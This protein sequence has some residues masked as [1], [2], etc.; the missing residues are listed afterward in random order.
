MTLAEVGW[1]PRLTNGLC[2]TGGVIR[3]WAVVLA[4][5]VLMASCGS[6]VNQV[7][8][9]TAPEG[10][11]TQLWASG[12][13]RPT[14]MVFTPGGDLVIAELNGGENA[15][16]GRILLVASDDANDRVVLQ[17][18]LDK[19]TGV[20]VTGELLWIMERQRLSV[21]TLEPGAPRDIVADDLPSNGRSEGTLTV[22]PDGRLLYNT[23]GSKRGAAR[24]AGSATL[25]AIDDA[26]LG[27]Q[28]PIVIATGFKHAYAHL[29]DESGQLWSVEMSDGVFDEIRASDELVAI[30]AGDDA[31]WPQCV[32]DN[33]PVV[34]F[35]GTE[36][37]CAASPSSHALFGLGATPTSLVIAPWDTDSFIVTLWLPGQVVT[38]PRSAPADG[39]HTPQVFIEGIESPQHLL[40]DGDGVLVSDHETGQI[41]R[42]TPA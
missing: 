39:P 42:I 18:G 11:Q 9:V 3:A 34:E 28:S 35:G 12:F 22:T 8:G 5:S 4:M 6:T 17:T 2:F 31:G 15:A 23:S 33:R 27:P 38:V 26:A 37:L 29:V 30:T 1:W 40:V 32:D 41:I 20:A 25:F 13:D 14:Q 21:T 19:P 24:V 36:A 16:L 7:E 10:F